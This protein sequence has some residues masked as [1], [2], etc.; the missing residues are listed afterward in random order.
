MRAIPSRSHR[1]SS[2]LVVGNHGSSGLIA[3]PSLSFHRAQA[4]DWGGGGDIPGELR[5]LDL[6]SP[7]PRSIPSPNAVTLCSVCAV[8]DFESHPA[9]KLM[10]I[11]LIDYPAA[12]RLLS[13]DGA[14]KPSTWESEELRCARKGGQEDKWGQRRMRRREMRRGK[15]GQKG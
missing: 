2:A 7:H 11:L 1:P 6:R 8:K 10:K 12:G 3:L 13:A 14:T 5:D 9:R 4:G 15:Q